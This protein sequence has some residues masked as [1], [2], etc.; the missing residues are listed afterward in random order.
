M[1]SDVPYAE[2]IGDPIAHSKSPFIHNFWLERLGM[3]GDYRATRVVADELPEFLKRRRSDA[4][5]RGCNV[6][7]PL[8][9]AASA[10]LDE[11]RSPARLHEP[12]NLILK[13][14][15]R[16]C[17]TN[18]DVAGVMESLR[19]VI[20]SPGG[21][22]L[23][24]DRGDLSAVVLGSGGVLL[25][26]TRALK[27]LG[28]HAVTVVAR[29]EDKLRGLLAEGAGQL[30]FLPWGAPLPPSD[31]LVNA[32]PLGMNGRPLLPY[33][34]TSVLPAG[35]VFEMIYD[36]LSTPLLQDAAARGLR[37]VDGLQMLVAQ[38]APSFEQLFGKPPPRE[39]DDE[40]RKLLTS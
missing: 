2:V 5:W 7:M 28:Y 33:D 14:G 38:A 40:L 34:A 26:V 35:V 25:S 18:T 6:T 1:M 22:L 13:E 19:K 11:H 9:L 32:T 17:G 8:K 27:T 23:K 36:P 39:H 21:A 37:C 30:R 24:P 20:A 15:E 4:L 12:I 10:L 3:A 29:S 16:L 31:L